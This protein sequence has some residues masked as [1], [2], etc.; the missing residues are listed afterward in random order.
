MKKI[1]QNSALLILSFIFVFIF[2]EIGV[3]I[4]WEHSDNFF[5]SDE[6]IGLIHIPNKE[7]LFVNK[8][9]SNKIKINSRGFVGKDY[10]YK[11]EEGI[12]RAVVL[13]DS[14]VEAI[15]VSPEN[16]FSS[17]L[18][19]EL[20]EEGKKAEVINLGMSSFG[21][22]REYLTLKH[23]G[24]QYQP[25]LI[26]LGFCI[27]NDVYNNYLED[28]NNPS[29]VINEDSGPKKQL[30]SFLLKNII[31]ANYF[32]EKA[33]SSTSLR[34][35]LMKMGIFNQA[36]NIGPL[37]EE[38]KIPTDYYVYA[39]EYDDVYQNGWE[40]TK[41]FFNKINQL[42]EENKIKFLAVL[43]PGEEQI[44]ENVWGEI[45][46]TYPGMKKREW[47]L[48]K[49]NKLLESY[50]IENK[51]DYLDLSSIIKEK[52]QS[53]EALYFKY[54]GHLTEA[55]HRVVSEGIEKYILDNNYLR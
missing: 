25:D 17:L 12:F 4:F 20:N 15:Q 45:K 22:G 29:F 10:D 33:Y 2:A 47:D 38:D 8:E 23:Y 16:N 42:A 40:K 35:I 46:D 21:T 6:K 19:K 24:L 31:L 52:S 28:E 26:I 49:P 41:Y 11:K 34:N 55:G 32:K 7:G 27:S 18:E 5:Q 54:D 37:D 1:L 36:K 50:F 30:K 3:R 43:I 51:I 9:F 48:E 14:L 39:K 44:Y 13:G 53:E